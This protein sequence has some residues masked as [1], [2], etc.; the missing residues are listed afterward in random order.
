MNK[1]EKKI[2]FWSPMLSH[3]GTLR[4]TIEMAESFNK[5]EN[6]KVFILNIFGEFNEYKN[7]NNFFIVNITNIIKFIPKIL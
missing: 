3:V 6:Y 5:Y 2:L 7:S 1:Q 4:A